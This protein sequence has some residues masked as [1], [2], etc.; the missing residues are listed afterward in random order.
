MG[1]PGDVEVVIRVYDL[2]RRLDRRRR[3]PRHGDAAGHVGCAAGVGAADVVADIGEFDADVAG[4]TETL[5]LAALGADGVAFVVAAAR[6]SGGARHMGAACPAGHH[7]V[8]VR[9][10]AV[11]WVACLPPA[12]EHV[13]DRARRH[14]SHRSREKLCSE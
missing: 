10:V 12:K 6:L 3:G 8:A 5:I 11:A 2:R 1:S 13:H 14:L 7:A 4:R 9:T